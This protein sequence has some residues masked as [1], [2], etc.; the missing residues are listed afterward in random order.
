M[1]CPPLT[2]EV[3]QLLEEARFLSRELLNSAD[4]EPQIR[5]RRRD[6]LRHLQSVLR[7]YAHPICH[8]PIPMA[9]IPRSVRHAFVRSALLVSR[10]HKLSGCGWQGTLHSPTL[11]QYRPDPIPDRFRDPQIL[12]ALAEAFELP[13]R[14]RDG[15]RAELADIDLRIGRQTQLVTAVFAS[16]TD[17]GLLSAPHVLQL[18]QYL[19]G[20]IPIPEDALNCIHTSTQIYFCL[21]YQGLRLRSEPLWASL[22]PS[23]RFQIEQFLGSLQRH[24][25][26]QFE[27]FPIF[28]PCRPKHIDRQWCE[29]IAEKTGIAAFEVRQA[30]RRSTSV[31]PTERAE[32]FLLHDIWGHYWQWIL[33]QFQ[34]DYHILAAC[35]EA[36]RGAETAY[37]PQ[38]PLSC[39]DLFQV[40]PDGSQVE[41]DTERTQLFFH[42]EVRQR[43]GL[44]F[45]HIL[46]ETIADMAE[47]K[48]IEDNP[49]SSERLPSSSIFK[50]FPTKLDLGLGD[51]DFLFLRVL[52]PL[53][54]VRVSIFEDGQLETDLSGYW[55]QQ[56]GI[57]THSERFKASLKQAIVR[58]HQVFLEGYQQSYLPS[59][60][61]ESSLF[62]NITCNL[63]YLQNVVNYL[64][65]EFEHPHAALLP[66]RDL[67]LV[68]IGSYCSRE[69]YADFWDIDD[70][71]AGYF[72][73]CW[74][75][76]R[77]FCVR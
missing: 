38:G 37:T 51:I 74:H 7:Q 76:L 2:S 36:L 50:D 52:Q 42:G 60:S 45:T 57:Q 66:F 73:P 75:R 31:L 15:L 61:N 67:M 56:R 18:F 12:S 70:V 3:R 8:D 49:E 77:Q 55:R 6:R 48:F 71:L 4:R 17:G 29:A 34:S 30:L 5:A 53:L 58:M 21:D 16:V 28:G 39:W 44:M 24:D 40:S 46:G 68:F 35:E 62:A 72:L 13:A 14:E 69:S 27:Q 43:L 9:E 32:T 1:P 41:L 33:T 59:S 23:E 25:L 47:F 63:L 54:D 64:C 19:F 11:S 22:T 65:A 26:G 10:Y 20:A